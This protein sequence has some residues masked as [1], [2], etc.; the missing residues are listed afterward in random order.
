[1]SEKSDFALP[2]PL[3]LFFN[4]TFPDLMGWLRIMSVVSDR[5]LALFFRI[6]NKY[7][8]YCYLLGVG[9]VLMAG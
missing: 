1:M 7:A 9:V 6:I 8:L 5:Q 2:S 4:V 3:R